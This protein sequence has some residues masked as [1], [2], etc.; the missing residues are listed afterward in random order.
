VGTFA[1]VDDRVETK[2]ARARS[3]LSGSVVTGPDTTSWQFEWRA[4]QELRGPIRFVVTA[5]AA[6]DD[7]SP[8]GDVIHRIQVEVP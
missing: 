2:D 3:T 5:N 1:A 7:G 6:N 8:L 4:P